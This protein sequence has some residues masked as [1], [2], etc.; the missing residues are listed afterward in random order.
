MKLFSKKIVGIDFHDY[1]AQLV[2]LKANG[3]R[4]AMESYNRMTIPPGIIKKGEIM[5]NDDLKII[6][7]KLIDSSNPKKINAKNV[8]V[9]FP[10]EKIF[11]HIFTFPSNLNE[12]DI[13]KAVPYQA[14]TVIPFAIQDV[15]WDFMILEKEKKSKKHASQYVLFAAITKEIADSY[16]EVLESIG[17]IPS[18]FGIQVESLKAALERQIK[19]G[20]A[21]MI[22]DNGALSTNYLIIKNGIIKYF[23]SSS[24]SGKK[25]VNTLAKE[26]Q[27]PESSILEEK[28]KSK[29]GKVHYPQIKKYSEKNHKIAQDILKENVNKKH[30]G[31]INEI[32]FTGEFLN[33]PG[34][35][36]LAKVYFPNQKVSLGDP[37]EGLYIDPDR[38]SPLDKKEELVPYSIYFTNAIGIGL[39]GLDLKPS[40][41]INLLPDRLRE[42]FKNKK[43]ALMVVIAS[44]CMSAI[45]LFLATFMFFQHQDLTYQ[46]INLET[47]KSAIERMI[48]GTSYQEI[49]DEIIRFNQEVSELSVID[50]GLF[51][52]SN[53]F[54]EIQKLVPK[55]VEIT[56]IKYMDEDLSVDITGIANSRSKLLEA[57]KNFENSEF[58]SEVIAPTLNYDAKSQ[59][60]F[61]F[62]LKLDFTKLEIYGSDPTT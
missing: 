25:L 39:R 26:L 36:E 43:N 52:T 2:E 51:S 34:Y 8:A 27:T 54:L 6:L 61:Y 9:I 18:L 11:T 31:P 57:Q 14:E 59:I 15:Y 48:Y 12:N 10:S 55:D 50:N 35:F 16:T 53:M 29:L 5:K 47:E 49:R 58:I 3:E 46:R 21:G 38:F 44:I 45:S 42:S 33:I 7:K 20:E 1:S 23:F 4:V 37:K 13:R 17:L 40:G 41:G 56:A 28:E 30:I 62:K 19:P 32:L 60:S 22:V 24:E